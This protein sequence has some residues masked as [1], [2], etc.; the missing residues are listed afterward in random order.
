MKHFLFSALALVFAN[1]VALVVSAQNNLP[2]LTY[3]NNPAVIDGVV[4]GFPQM[5]S[6]VRTIYVR[7]TQGIERIERTD[8]ALISDSGEFALMIPVEFSKIVTLSYGD[9]SVELLVTPGEILEVSYDPHKDGT[10]KHAWT[11]RRSNPEFNRDLANYGQKYNPNRLFFSEGYRLDGDWLK[12][13]ATVQQYKTR[14]LGIYNE[15]VAAIDA[16]THVGN[17]FKEYVKNTCM[18][19]TIAFLT[20]YAPILGHVNHKSPQEYQAPLDYYT[21]ILAWNP[22]SNN[23]VLYSRFVRDLRGFADNYTRTTGAVKARFPDSFTQLSKACEY[24][25]Q[26]DQHHPFSREQIGKVI[27]DC[28]V[29]G[30]SLLQRNARLMSNP[31]GHVSP[32]MPGVHAMPGASGT[33]LTPDSVRRQNK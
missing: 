12:G 32:G 5:S 10:R 1:S 21:D 8:S 31:F 29:L 9:K 18:I 26:L 20:A 25:D 4:R 16:D 13:V 7:F 30:L 6:H 19:Q 15:A 23:N 22:F 11:F 17:A 27:K 14:V 24:S 3:S 2:G 28:P 33:E